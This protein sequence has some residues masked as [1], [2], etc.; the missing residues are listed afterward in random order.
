MQQLSDDNP[1]T[2][3]ADGPLPSLGQET[4]NSGTTLVKI[5]GST[6]GSHDTTLQDLVTL[7]Q[8]GKPAIVVHGG[9]KVITEWME[10]QGAVSYTHLTLPT[11]LLV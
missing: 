8:T 9:G 5:G 1:N 11:I 6:L 7:Q 10:K 4:R 3:P 2:Q